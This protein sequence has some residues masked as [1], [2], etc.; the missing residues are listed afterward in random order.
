MNA[1]SQSLATKQIEVIQASTAWKIAVAGASK[2]SWKHFYDQAQV[3]MIF[4]S[5]LCN[6]E[7]L[8]GMFVSEQAQMLLAIAKRFVQTGAFAALDYLWVLTELNGPRTGN[9]QTLICLLRELDN[10]PIPLRTL[11]FYE[12]G[13]VAD[14]PENALTAALPYEE[15]LDTAELREY[16]SQ[17]LDRTTELPGEWEYPWA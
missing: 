3:C 17:I 16:E 13:S 4:R 6:R 1:L 11:E 15:T 7:E 10:L 9:W 14:S 5:M 12:N 8:L 2:R